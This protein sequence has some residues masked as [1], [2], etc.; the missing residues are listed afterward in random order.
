MLE[1][2]VVVVGGGIG[3]LTAAALL[4]A[5][6]LSVCL[7]ERNSRVG[8]CV[9]SFAQSGYEFEAGGGLYAGWGT[10]DIHPRVFAELR[11]TAPEPLRLSPAY[12]VRLFDGTDVRVGLEAGAH[13]EEIRRAFPE[14][15]DAARR[16]Y[17]EAAQVAATL[18][19]AASEMPGLATATRAQRLG[20]IARHWR[21]APRILSAMSHTVAPRLAGTSPRFRS[22]ID[23]QLRLFTATP[24]ADCSYLHG[25]VA[26]TEPL[27]GLYALGGGGQRL[28]DCLAEAINSGGG[29]LCLNTTALRLVLDSAGQAAGVELL[30]GERIAA[31][32]AVISNLTI[33][34]TYGKLVGRDRTPVSLSARLKTLRGAGAYLIFAGLEEK[35][36]GRLPAERM[37]A[38][39][40]LDDDDDAA[41]PLPIGQTQRGAAPFLFSAPGAN[42]ARAPSGQ[43]AATFSILCEPE[44]WFSFDA[45]A[46]ADEELDREMLEE[47]WARL[48]AALPELGSGAEVYETATPRD[49]YEQT[50]RRL[51]MVCGL[52]Q[53]LD[54]AGPHAPTHRTHIP[55]LYAVGDT[56][57]PGSGAA[58]VTLSALAAANEIAPRRP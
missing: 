49:Y 27:R 46:G 17:D 12:V 29:T 47:C 22:F 45:G 53:S 25:A 11:S 52:G 18:R 14:C 20:L 30:S 38:A 9:S 54:V 8:G 41:P 33:W 23:A 50:R 24:A 1:F 37:L 42:S 10:G 36:A 5:R 39:P 34:D 35:A 28:A 57:F 21:T 43:R 19:A 58:A 55:R 16:F 56:V 15:A 3:G 44:E 6:G 32:R 13:D 48:H 40:A 2:E 4:A 26:L 7:V 51:G 31:T